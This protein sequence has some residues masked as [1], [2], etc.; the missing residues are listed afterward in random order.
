MGLLRNPEVKDF[1]R[2]QFFFS[3][4]AAAGAA[5]LHPLFGVYVLLIS[6]AGAARYLAFTRKRYEAVSALS[7]QLDRILHGDY[8]MDLIPDEEG[9][10]ALLTSEIYKV[11]LR[12]KEQ[13]DA[14]EQ[15]T[16]YLSDSLADIS[17]QIRTPLTSMRMI[18]PRLQ[19]EEVTAEERRKYVGE[20][21]ALLSR[22]EW[23]VASLLKI[24]RLESGAA[25][26]Q[27]ERISAAE[28]VEKALSPVDIL[29]DLKEITCKV[30]IKE[31]TEFRGD[32]HWSAEA[33][34]NI[35]KNC[36]EHMPE[37]GR[38]EI[39]AEENPVYTEIMIT[40]SGPGIASEDIPHLFERFYRGKDSGTDH[41]GIGLALS[42]MIVHR[43][44][45]TIR[46]ENRSEGGARFTIR[47]Y[48]GAV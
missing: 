27:C 6:M 48:K 28:V 23:L 41:V 8:R 19:R 11:T 44:N 16:K 4:A 3:L 36:V 43:Q 15:E 20:V 35:L 30:S 40:D 45:G 31:K 5:L 18:V 29:I 21:I 14:L 13:A 39:S 37:R 1:F 17:H 10:L 47:F 22:T 26:V 32:I 34:G 24:A 2:F 7:C 46:V 25:V 12:L 42:R 33:V 9:E 38:L